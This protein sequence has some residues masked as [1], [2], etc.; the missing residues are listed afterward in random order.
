LI[1][2]RLLILLFFSFKNGSHP[3]DGATPNFFPDF[4]SFISGL[5][6]DVSFGFGFILKE[7]KHLTENLGMSILASVPKLW[8]HSFEKKL[9]QLRF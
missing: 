2:A 7:A 9:T 8:P 3:Q 6:N 4:A 5:S 1:F